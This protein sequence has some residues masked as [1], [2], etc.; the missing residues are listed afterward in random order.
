MT[1]QF[2][3]EQQ[4]W[5]SLAE[6]PDLRPVLDPGDQNGAKNELIDRIHR[7]AVADAVLA[8]ARTRYAGVIDVGCGVGRLTPSLLSY[9]DCVVGVDPAVNMLTRA[10]AACA[11]RR[12]TFYERLQDVPGLPE[13]VLVVSVYVL[14]IIPRLAA[15]DLLSQLAQH[16]G[17]GAA[18][19]L[20]ERI[21]PLSAP[22]LDIEKRSVEWYA[23]SLGEAG[24]TLDGHRHVRRSDSVPQRINA[25]LARGTLT[26]AKRMLVGKLADLELRRAAYPGLGAYVDVAM[27]GHAQPLRAGT[28]ARSS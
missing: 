4:D 28:E 14:C 18:L 5:E 11:D 25:R 17:P 24:W 6:L 2:S 21:A 3:A 15:I 23:E 13:P 16:A 19:V 9:G 8:T 10:R 26:R 27:W 20:I 12:A 7:C 22:E 1:Q